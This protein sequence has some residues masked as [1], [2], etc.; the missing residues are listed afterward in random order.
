LIFGTSYK[1]QYVDP[2]LFLVYQL[3]RLSLSAK[4]LLVIGYGFGD[5][6]INGILKQA[7][8]AGLKKLVVVTYLGE[9]EG[10]RLLDAESAFKRFATKQLDVKESDARFVLFINKA[11]KFFSSGLTLDAMTQLFPPEEEIFEELSPAP[12]AVADAHTAAAAAVPDD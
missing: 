10:D 5:E 4:L 3:R 7:L 8:R 6:H 9:L 1:L 11:E 12:Q 2:F